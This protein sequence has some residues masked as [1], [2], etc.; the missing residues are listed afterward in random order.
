MNPILS[1]AIAIPYVLL[2]I[3]AMV[4]YFKG[5]WK[6]MRF[7]VDDLFNGGGPIG[8]DVL[9][10]GICWVKFMLFLCFGFPIAII[11]FVINLLM[12]EKKVPLPRLSGR[13]EIK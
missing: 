12:G 3:F 7:A 11:V 4:F 13:H 9:L 8:G 5:L 6:D 2:N 10:L 1:W